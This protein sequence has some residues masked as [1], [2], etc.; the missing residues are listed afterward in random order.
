MQI[1]F[2]ENDHEKRAFI[3]S[4]GVIVLTILAVAAFVLTGGSII[5]YFFMVLELILGFYMVYHISNA[6]VEEKPPKALAKKSGR[7]R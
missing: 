1:D 4:L 7:K 6:P 2:L 5:F 3:F